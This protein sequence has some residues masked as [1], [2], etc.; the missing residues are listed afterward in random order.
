MSI[1]TKTRVETF[2]VLR[3]YASEPYMKFGTFIK[4]RKHHGLSTEKWE[5]CFACEH[6]FEDDED[7]YLGSVTRRGN[8]AFCKSCAEKYNTEKAEGDKCLTN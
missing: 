8:I 5:K 6:A 3:A 2:K 4:Q 1:I 7:I